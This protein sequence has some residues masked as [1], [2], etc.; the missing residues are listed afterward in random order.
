[1]AIVTLFAYTKRR[2]NASLRSAA[3]RLMRML[4]LIWSWFKNDRKNN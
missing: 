2:A 3:M 4:D 1:M